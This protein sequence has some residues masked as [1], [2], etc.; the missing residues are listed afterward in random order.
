[1]FARSGRSRPPNLEMAGSTAFQSELS[2]EPT[3]GISEL[4]PDP[5]RDAINTQKPKRTSVSSR[6]NLTSNAGTVDPAGVDSADEVVMRPNLDTNHGGGMGDQAKQG[7]N[8]THVMSFMDY[9]SSSQG[10]AS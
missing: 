9:D 10:P 1:M 7:G 5:E 4:S 6:T 3:T 2:G 8:R